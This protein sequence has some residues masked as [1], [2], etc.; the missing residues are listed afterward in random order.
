VASLWTT[1]Q[2]IAD[3]FSVNMRCHLQKQANWTSASTIPIQCVSRRKYKK[4]NYFVKEVDFATVGAAHLRLAETLWCQNFRAFHSASHGLFK[5]GSL[6]RQ[7]LLRRL[8]DT[9]YL[10]DN[11]C[12]NIK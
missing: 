10:I 3:K 2:T 4:G 12:V 9:L 5:L 11:Y 8:G 1:A 7:V 6:T